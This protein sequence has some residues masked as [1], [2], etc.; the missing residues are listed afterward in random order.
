M[1]EFLESGKIWFSGKMIDWRDAKIHV[2][3]H[4][5]HYGSSV[6]EGF[7]CYKT[8]RGP[9]IFRLKDHI[10]RLYDSAKIYRIPMPF[11]REVVEQACI[12]VVKINGLEEAYIRPIAFRGYG[13]LGVDPK[14]TPTELVVGALAWG[15]YLGDEAIN[16]GVD[17]RVSSWNRMRPNTFPAMA[18]CGANYMNS[19]LINLEA[20]AD[21]YIE[22]IALDAGGLVSEGSGENIFVIRDGKIYTP[23]LASSV[24]PGIT[25]D[26]VINLAEALGYKIEVASIPREFLYIADEVFFTGSAA[27]VSPIKSIDR[28]PIG[29]GRRGPITEK[30]QKHFFGILTGEI[31]DK[32]G[33]LTFI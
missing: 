7:R 15:K 17:V 4:V 29:Q 22:G 16:V 27:E 26:C 2:M 6:F 25:R 14:D 28:I 23:S 21:G 8:A 5:L 12:D 9:A 3:C 19:Q 33:W 1:S 31:E 10:R 18:K 30:I 32:Y 20:K 24:L 13:S 11:S